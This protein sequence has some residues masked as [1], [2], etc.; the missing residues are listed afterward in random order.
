[1]PED[2]LPGDAEDGSPFNFPLPPEDRLW[3]HPSEIGGQARRGGPLPL[4]LPAPAPP[5]PGRRFGGVGT[6]VVALA[7]GLLGSV[8]TV[9]MLAVVG[10]FDARVVEQRTVEQPPGPG[11]LSRLT[12]LEVTSEDTATVARR[13]EPALVRLEVNAPVGTATATAVSLGGEFLLTSADLLR[14]SDPGTAITAVLP[15]AKRVA[16]QVVAEDRYTNLV[17]LRLPGASLPTPSWGSS[18]TLVAGTDVLVVGAAEE[19]ARSATVARGVIS[20]VGVRTTVDNGVTLHD[21]LRLDANM[22]PVSRGGLVLDANGMVV[23]LV[24]TFASDGDG[25]ERIGLATPIEL[26]RAVADSIM[27]FGRPTEVWLGV[28]G[29]TLTPTEASTLN[30]DGGA[31]ITT[32]TPQ[33][34]AQVGGLAAG[35]V[36]TA[37][38]QV[39]VD[40]FTALILALRTHQPGDPVV[41]SIVRGGEIRLV[42]LY[43][44]RRPLAEQERASGPDGGADGADET[45]T[46]PS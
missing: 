2:D 27:R 12:S 18:E 35:D 20:S 31:L 43:L 30:L 25:S 46:M 42:P 13:T 45:H 39:P 32:V 10:A 33:G 1:M 14:R 15:D 36:V 24:S 8:L 28:D 22:A 41:L 44:A 26:A 29:Q 23:G 34:P 37:V 11:S 40:T 17:V 7:G 19:N 21:L 3:R 6:A 38:D 5:L 4:P 9:G 16:A